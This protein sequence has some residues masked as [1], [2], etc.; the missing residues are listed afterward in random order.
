MAYKNLEIT[1][2]NTAYQQST[3][4][5][6]FYK[7]FS[8]LDDTNTGSRLYDLDLIKQDIINNFNTRKGSRVMKPNYGSIIWDLLMEP[9]TDQTRESLKDDVT[10]IC[11]ADPRVVPTQM[12]LTEYES[13]YLLEITLTLKAT[14]E[15]AS[16]RLTFDQSIGLVAQ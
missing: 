6:H 2:V 10:R 3:K 11:T 1:G 7:G 4:Q 12:D 15:S 16:M 5:Q 9:L 13:G 14:N 8:S